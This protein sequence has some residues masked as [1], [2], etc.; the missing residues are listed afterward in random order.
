MQFA[1]HTLQL[2]EVALADRVAGIVR[3]CETDERALVGEFPGSPLAVTALRARG[4]PAAR[5]G[6][7]GTRTRRPVSWS[8]RAAS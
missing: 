1:A 3:D 7:P 5:R 2:D 6:G 4:E 8:R